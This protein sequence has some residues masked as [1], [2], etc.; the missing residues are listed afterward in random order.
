LTIPDVIW[1]VLLCPPLIC[2][3]PGLR[4]DRHP[5]FCTPPDILVT[6]VQTLAQCL[7]S[8]P[9]I[10]YPVSGHR[11]NPCH[12]SSGPILDIPSFPFLLRT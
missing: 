5:S 7:S 9:S 11:V 3:Y 6:S 2:V 8:G 4:P 12:T 10:V 1:I